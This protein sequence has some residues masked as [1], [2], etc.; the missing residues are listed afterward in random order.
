MP[1]HGFVYTL[2]NNFAKRH[3]W[4]ELGTLGAMTLKF[5]LGQDFCTCTYT[6]SFIF[7]CLIVQK[8]S[9]WQTSKPTNK[10]TPLKPDSM[11]WFSHWHRCRM[12]FIYW[13]TVRRAHILHNGLATCDILGV[14]NGGGAYDPKFELGWDFCTLPLSTLSTKFHHSVFNHL[15]V[16]VLTN[17]TNP[18]KIRCHWKHPPC[19][20]M[21]HWWITMQYYYWAF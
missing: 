1:T 20:T 5:E 10:W 16:I 17:I 4:G 13:H 7:P 12:V 15:E 18:Q 8:L 21:L 11:R 3:I 2:W 6:P 9:C 19:F 14:G